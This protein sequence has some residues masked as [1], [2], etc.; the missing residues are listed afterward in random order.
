MA[1]A[2][3]ALRT[4]PATPARDSTF[5]GAAPLRFV[6]APHAGNA[7]RTVT[8][9]AKKGKDV[10]LMITLECT[11]QKATGVGG[12]SRYTSEKA[13]PAHIE[14]RVSTLAGRV[15][16]ARPAGGFRWRRRWAA[17]GVAR[18]RGIER[19]QSPL[20]SASA[21]GCALLR[22]VRARVARHAR[23]AALFRDKRMHA[24]GVTPRLHACLR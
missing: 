18:A 24:R 6:A 14:A 4:A 13:R 20:A 1:S 15:V 23:A 9:M 16:A 21:H 2:R 19:R 5:M 11:E 12:I 17:A 10:R 22:G 3:V 8:C 7:C